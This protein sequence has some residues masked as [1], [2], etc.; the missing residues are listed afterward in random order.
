MP[1]T[2]S[3]PEVTAPLNI[4]EPDNPL[5]ANVRSLKATQA[6]QSAGPLATGAVQAAQWGNAVP[7]IVRG[8]NNGRRMAA[9]NMFP[10]SSQVDPALWDITTSGAAIMRNALLY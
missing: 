8:E 2:F 1:G 9:L 7:L 4:L 6:L 10:P 3:S 5:V